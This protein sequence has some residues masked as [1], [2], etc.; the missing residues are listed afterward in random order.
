MSSMTTMTRRINFGLINHAAMAELP[1]LLRRWL[2]HGRIQGNEF[3]ARNPTRH[4]R[5]AGSFR[6]NMQTGKWADFATYDRGGDVVSLAAYLAGTGQAEAARK[7][8][9]MLGLRYD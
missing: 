4:D 7:L 3:V 6:I 2:P 1:T 5:R 9:D 8:A